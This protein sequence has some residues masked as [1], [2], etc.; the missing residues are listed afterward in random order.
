MILAQFTHLVAN[1][2][3][4]GMFFQ[5]QQT[6]GFSPLDLWHNMGSLAKGVVIILF[7]M[8]IWSLAVIIDRW[9]YFSA[10]RKQSR[11]F[12]PRLPAH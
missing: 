2:S 5:E 6:V 9:L 11:E 12:A 1:P 8:S 7:V 3:A 10:A 4:L